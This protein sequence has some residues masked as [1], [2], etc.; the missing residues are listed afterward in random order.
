MIGG[1]G[2]VKSP[3]RFGCIRVHDTAHAEPDEGP[4]SA[5]GV[6]PRRIVFVKVIRDHYA[7]VA[8]LTRAVA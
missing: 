7:K 2:L 5:G 3:A 8:L 6:K 1:R 4:S